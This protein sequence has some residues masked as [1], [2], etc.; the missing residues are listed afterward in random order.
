MFRHFTAFAAVALTTAGLGAAPVSAAI[1][2]RSFVGA[3][4]WADS[5]AEQHRGRYKNYRPG[6]YHDS[7]A[8]RRYEQQRRYEQAR[9]EQQ[10]RYEQQQRRYDSRYDDRYRECDR[11]RGG[12]VAG[13]V[14]GGLLGNQAARYGDKTGGAVL[15]AVV[16]GV[17]GNVIDRRDDPCRGSRTRGGRRY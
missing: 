9:Y 13:A 16:G 10:R 7:R 11:G 17:L 1:H 14:V 3:S 12:A 2:D 6:G 15:G 8:E 4:T 5:S